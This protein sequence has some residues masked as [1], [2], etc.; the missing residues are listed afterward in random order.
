MYTVVGEFRF[1]ANINRVVALFRKE[2]MYRT[3]LLFLPLL[4]L[5]LYFLELA[6][7]FLKKKK[8]QLRQ[9][10]SFEYVDD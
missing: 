8:F 4:Y 1:F 2:N 6:E 3:Y 7:G 5:V 9:I 10:I